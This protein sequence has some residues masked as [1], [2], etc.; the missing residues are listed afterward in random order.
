M[1]RKIWTEPWSMV[2]GFLI[3]GGLVVLGFLLEWTIGPVKWDAFAWPVNGI[4]LIA[5]LLLI[6]LFR[7]LKK[8]V[9]AFQFLS[10]HRA[11]VPALAFVTVFTLVMGLAR[12]T[13]EGTWFNHMLTCWPFVLVYVY[14]SVILG[15]IVIR[16]IVHFHWKRDIPFLLNHFGL[17]LALITAT[18]GNPDRQEMKML[19]YPGETEWRAIDE[20][21]YIVEMPFGIEL[22]R[23]VMETFEDGSPKRFASQVVIETKTGRKFSTTVDVNNPVEVD[24]WKIYQY[25]YDSASGAMSEFSVLELVRDPWQPAVYTGICMMLLGAL[26]LFVLG[27]RKKQHSSHHHSSH[28][29]SSHHH[30]EHHSHSSNTH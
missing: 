15:L 23:F 12:Q 6:G 25:D 11:A 20:N 29:H 13:E 5:F 8:Q 26:G 4:V 19:V 14:I 27:V 24:G 22:K 21:Q 7:S 17:F 2:E 1:A 9:Y 28:H 30:S 18:L 16:H 3:A 10:T